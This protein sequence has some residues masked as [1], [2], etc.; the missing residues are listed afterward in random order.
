MN[1]CDRGPVAVRK[2]KIAIREKGRGYGRVMGGS[3]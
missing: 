2:M 3:V 1:R